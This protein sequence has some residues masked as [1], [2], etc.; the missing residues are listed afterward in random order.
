MD[1]ERRR[2]QMRAAGKTYREKHKEE[3]AEKSRAWRV[4]NPEKARVTRKRCDK[5]HPEYKERK[6]LNSNAHLARRRNLLN[7]VC[8]HYGC[9][10]PGCACRTEGYVGEELDMHHLKDKEFTVS[11]RLTASL[12]RIAA[13][14][15]KCVVLCANCHRRF[16]AGRF[17][18]DESMLCLVDEKLRPIGRPHTA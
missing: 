5:K 14:V 18:V 15:N 2:A 13:E 6:M 4:A 10:N 9:R 8:V 16:H 11:Q 17:A 1:I 7:A 3:L 12:A